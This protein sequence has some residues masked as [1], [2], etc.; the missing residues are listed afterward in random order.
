MFNVGAVTGLERGKCWTG[1]VGCLAVLI[2]MLWSA[3]CVGQIQNPSFEDTYDG[4]PAPRPLPW[5]WYPNEY[6]SFNSYCTNFWSTN[7]NLSACLCS[8]SGI[9]IL[10]GEFQGFYQFI[11]L[12]DV[13]GIIFD[14]MLL[15]SDK[16]GFGAFEA[17]LIVTSMEDG[18]VATVWSQSAEGEYLDQVADVRAF[19]GMCMIE[20]RLTATADATYTAEYAV[21]WDNLA[22]YEWPTSIAADIGL[23][24][25]TMIVGCNNKWNKL[26]RWV[27]C[28]I[29]LEAGYDAT[30]IDGSTVF[31]ND[32]PAYMGWEWWARPEANR[33]NITDVDWD[34]IPE[35]VVA[36]ERAGLEAIV[37]AP[38]TTVTVRGLL[39]DGTRFQ[40]TAV[41]KVIDKR[42]GGP[43]YGQRKPWSPHRTWRF[44]PSCGPRS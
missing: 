10:A 3:A 32:I 35:R 9:G 14:A 17:S 7:G 24:P 31:L 1:R 26:F 29:E 44:H 16:G 34:G 38:E 13:D 15:A 21:F 27:T 4:L 39:L 33:M 40:G 37:T 11:D 12:T 20:L 28:F 6:S 25:D 30:Q 19:T 23:F 8:R 43:P 41:I 22:F 18:S 42:A 36:F 2:A 5:Y